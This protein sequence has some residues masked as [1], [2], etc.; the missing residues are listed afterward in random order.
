MRGYDY[1][2]S[3]G[4]HSE[5][6]YRERKAGLFTWMPT[7][8]DSSGTVN[9]LSLLSFFAAITRPLSPFIPA[10]FLVLKSRSRHFKVCLRIPAEMNWG[11]QVFDGASV[12]MIFFFYFKIVA[13]S[14]K[15]AEENSFELL[16]LLGKKTFQ[17]FSSRFTQRGELI[18]E[19]KDYN[20]V[21]AARM[22][23]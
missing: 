13:I 22:E 5:K 21:E 9:L 16:A 8:N 17:F 11:R 3:P 20:K 23:K 14:D 18:K 10:L 4:R 15:S 7:R 12:V 2:A 6:K 19:G 1:W